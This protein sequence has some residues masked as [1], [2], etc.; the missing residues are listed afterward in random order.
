MTI[1]GPAPTILAMFLN[2]AIDQQLDRFARENTA[3]R[4][5]GSR[6]RPRCACCTLADGSR[7]GAGRHPQGGPGPEHLHLLHR[8]RARD[9]GRHPGV[10]R[11]AQHPQLLLGLHQRLPHRRGRR[12]PHHAAGLHAGQRFH[13]R[14]VYLAGAWRRR[15]RAQPLL[16]LLQR[17]GPRVH[18]HRPGGPADL[19]DR[20]A[21]PLRRDEQAQKLKYHVQT[22]GRSLHAQEMAFNDIRTTLQALCAIYDNCNSLHTN[23]FDEAVTTPTEES[24]RRALAIQLII[25]KEW[26]LA[27]NENPLQGSSSSRSSPTWWRRRCSRSSSAS[28]SAAGCSGAMETGYQRGRIQDESMLYEHEAHRLSPSSGSTPSS[29]PTPWPR[30][31]CGL[32]S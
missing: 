22:S 6:G 27:M 7:H 30:I 29:I 10:L 13:L 20:H 11:R 12:E 26:G 19:G 8:V 5:H 9:D 3:G 28:P 23:A 25:N 18:G 32:P 17:H 15:L 4:A 1:N 2:T 14:G 16:L 31:T 24:V 21:R